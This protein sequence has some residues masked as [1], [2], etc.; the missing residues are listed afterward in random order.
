[1]DKITFLNELEYQLHRLPNHVVDEV[2]NEYENHFY[3]EGLDGK[4]DE[5][6]VNASRY[7]KTNRE[8][9]LCE[10]RSQKC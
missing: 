3:R 2:M 4:S 10:I 5:A 9:T 1:M 8:A 7:T 6:I